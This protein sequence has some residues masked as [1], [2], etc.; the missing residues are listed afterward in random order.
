M[1]PNTDLFRLIKSLTRN[2]K[3]Y[4]KKYA[5]VHG[6]TKN[7][8]Y[9]L[10]FDEIDKQQ[11]TYDEARLIARLKGKPMVHHLSVVK[12]YLFEMILKSLRSFHDQTYML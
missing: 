9:L 2:E 10:L 4:F 7:A 1:K 3:G 6:N 8:D 5:Q 12:N 11:D